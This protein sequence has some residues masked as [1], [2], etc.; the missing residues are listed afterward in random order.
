VGATGE[1]RQRVDLPLPVERGA[2]EVAAWAEDAAS[3]EVLQAL[4]LP[5]C[6]HP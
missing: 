4:V 2:F 1:L 6:A 3:G 5:F